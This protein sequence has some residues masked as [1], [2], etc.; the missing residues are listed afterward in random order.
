MPGLQL[1]YGS[2]VLQAHAFHTGYDLLHLP[3]P[4][5]HFFFEPLY[6]LV[7]G[8][9]LQPVRVLDLVEHLQPHGVSVD[10]W[11]DLPFKLLVLVA[12]IQQLL[13]YFPDYELELLLSLLIVALLTL[14]FGLGL[15]N[16]VL[17]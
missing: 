3:L 5:E 7:L 13:L 17:E 6:L 11:S 1:P 16:L 8:F 9:D 2:L 15:F 14:Q 12:L 4:A 10:E